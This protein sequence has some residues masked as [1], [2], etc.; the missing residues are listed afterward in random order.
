M[1][2]RRFGWA[3]E[4]QLKKLAYK[5]ACCACHEAKTTCKGGAR[6]GPQGGESDPIAAFELTP[7]Q[8]VVED[9]W[10]SP[11]VTH[12]DLVSDEEVENSDEE[13]NS[14]EENS[15]EDSGEVSDGAVP[16]KSNNSGHENYASAEVAANL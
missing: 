2:C 15:D 12:A 10:F 7:A 6:A 1:R 5:S 4:D 13:D 16:P 14:D 9:L 11:G 8:V 3:C